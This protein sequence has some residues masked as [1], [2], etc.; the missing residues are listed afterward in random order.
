LEEFFYESVGSSFFLNAVYIC[1]C[2]RTCGS[3]GACLHLSMS[4]CVCSY[5]VWWQEH[6]ICHNEQRSSVVGSS[7]REIRLERQH[8]QAASIAAGTSQSE[9]DTEGP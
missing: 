8:V 4:F 9:A 3:V 5:L 2:T 7:S 1:L 6:P